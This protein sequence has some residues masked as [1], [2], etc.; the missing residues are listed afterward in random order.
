MKIL[1]TY[2]L[3]FAA[4]VISAQ[5]TDQKTPDSKKWYVYLNGGAG[6]TNTQYEK[7]TVSNGKLGFEY[8][9]IPYIGLGMGIAGSNLAVKEKQSSADLLLPLLLLSGSSSSS[10]S[11]SFL[12]TIILLDML[13]S[14]GTS[15]LSYNTLNLDFN[16]H[17]NQDKT[18][19]PYIGIGVIGGSCTGAATCTVTGG[20]GRLGVQFNF[21]TFFFFLQGQYQSLSFKAAD[22]GVNATNTIGSLGLGAR[23]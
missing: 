10:S 2:I 4:A 1:F 18:F 20:E 23:F 16:F 15:K 13:S 11:S 22:S 3:L 19:D 7:G 5:E 6:N 21:S 14:G 12:T 9:P 17:M 8:R